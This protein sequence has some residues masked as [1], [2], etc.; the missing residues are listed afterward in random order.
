LN[1]TTLRGSVRRTAVLA[2]VAVSAA[3]ALA[4]GSIGFGGGAV[5]RA[6]IGGTPV[7]VGAFGC[8]AGLGGGHRTVPAGSTIVIR[9]GW[10][11]T[12]FGS[13]RSFLDAQTSILSVND[14]PMVDASDAYAEPDRAP[15]QRWATWLRYPTGVTLASPGDAMR[16]TFALVFDRPLTD[17]SD[18]DGDGSIDPLVPGHAGL[19]FGGTCTVTA[20]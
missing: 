13:Q 12:V 15:D 11:S 14:G 20:T 5:A 19:A 2:L 3:S 18:L 16:F 6:D 10:I 4:L 7:E 8:I 1:V 9:N 17:T